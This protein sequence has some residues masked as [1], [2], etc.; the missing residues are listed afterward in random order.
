MLANYSLAPVQHVTSG[1]ISSVWWRTEL[2][3]CAQRSC[4]P[5]TAQVVD[6]WCGGNLQKLCQLLPLG[7][8]STIPCYSN[9]RI[10]SYLPSL[11]WNLVWASAFSP[12]TLIYLVCQRPDLCGFRLGGLVS[13]PGFLRRLGND[14]LIKFLIYVL[15]AMQLNIFV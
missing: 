12:S 14:L 9:T 5:A 1:G 3:P 7:I 8:S 13:K 10:F 4:W 2:C 6:S 15:I 11:F